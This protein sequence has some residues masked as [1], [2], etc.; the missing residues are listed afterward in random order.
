MFLILTDFIASFLKYIVYMYLIMQLNNKFKNDV[1]E[2]R[3]KPFQ[4]RLA[5]GIM[6]CMLF[7]CVYIWK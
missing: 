5:S 7:T 4:L 2:L 3:N 1:L 6:N